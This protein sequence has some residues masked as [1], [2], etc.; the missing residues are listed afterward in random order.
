M[1]TQRLNIEGMS[2]GHCVMALKKELSKI[3]GV[4]IKAA[5]VG[6]AELEVDETRVTPEV[7]RA[8]VEEA[9]Y[10]LVAIQ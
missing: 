8:A 2:C 1:K 5:E 4:T 6:S 10:S 3:E 7:L 9:G